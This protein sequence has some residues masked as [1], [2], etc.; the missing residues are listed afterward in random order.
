[1]SRWFDHVCDG[2]WENKG[3]TFSNSSHR[4]LWEPWSDDND[5]NYAKCPANRGYG[6]VTFPIDADDL[7]EGAV[8]DS[9][10]V[11]VRLKTSA[12]S[13]PRAVSVSV[14]SSDDMSRFTN[15]TLYATSAFVTY[16]LGT[17]SKDPLGYAWDIHRLNKLRLRIYALQDT[18]DS[19]RVA[20]LWARVNYH[21]R[22]TTTVIAPSGT[23]ITPTP[24][25]QWTYDQADAEPQKSAEYRIFTQQKVTETAFS[26][27]TATPVLQGSVSGQSTVVRVGTNFNNGEY[28]VYVRTTSQKGATSNWA[29]KSFTVLAPSPGVPG[30]D[31]AG[32]SGIPGVGT[33]TAIPDA[34]SSS[35][36]LRMRDASNLLS[37]QQADFEILSDPLEYT[38]TG[39][40][41][42]RSTSQ[43]FFNGEAS[44]SV[45]STA[46][47]NV[48]VRSTP[49]EV[50]PSLPITL[51]TQVL[52]KTSVRAV[53]L[54]AEFYDDEFNLLST[55]TAVTDTDSTTTWRELV[56][57]TTTPATTAYL[58]LLVTFTSVASGEVHYMDKVGV[59]YG[60]GA[61][62]T[63][64]GHQ[65]RNVLSSYLAT[66]DDPQS[67]T[68]SWEQTN[69]ATTVQRVTTS[70]T[71]AHG[72][73]THQ[74][75]YAGAS[76]GITFR[77]TS[78]VYT[79]PTTGTNFTL[80][81]PAGVTDN[82]LLLAFVTSTEAGDIVPPT[83]WTAVN[84][85]SIDDPDGDVAL[86]ILKRTAT[87]ADPATWTDGRLSVASARRSAVV[88]AYAG[89]AHADDQFIA[90]N[91]RSDGA[92]S[93]THRTQ[94]VT[95]W[96][97]K[98][99]RVAAFAASSGVTGGSLSANITPPVTERPPPIH[100]IGKSPACIEHK[101]NNTFKLYR[102]EGV[103]SGDL[104]VAGAVFSGRITSVTP[105][106]GWS[107]VR[108]SHQIFPNSSNGD[109]HSGDV[110]VAVFK[111]TAGS[112][113]PASWTGSHSDW[114]QP[115][116][117]QVLAYRNC[118]DASTQ[119]TSE[120]STGVTNQHSAPTA[121]ITNNDSRSWRISMFGATTPFHS[122]WEGG[123]SEQRCSSSTSLDNFPDAVISFSDSNGEISTGSHYRTGVINSI[124]NQ[125][126]NVPTGNFFT[127]IGWI[128][129]IK[130][131]PTP[132]VQGGNETERTDSTIGNPAPWITTAVYDSNGAIPRGET[133][134]YGQFN[135]GTATSANSIVSWIGIIK[136]A[137]S[138]VDG[139]AQVRT[140][141]FVDISKIGDPLDLAG[142]KLTVMSSFLGSS[143]GQPMLGLQF[144]RANQLISE[145]SAPGAPFGTSVWRKAWASFTV[146]SGTTRVRP[147]ISALN[148]SVGD[149]VKFD[150]I[151]VLLGAP[152][153]DETP[154]WRNGTAR[155]EH[156]VWSKP[157]I[158]YTDDTGSGYG[159]WSDL[160]AQKLI[161]PTF[162]VGTGLLAYID[163]TVIPLNQRKYR[164]QTVAYG[165]NGDK[166]LSGW[167]PESGEV[168]FSAV[169]W[170]LKDFANLEGSL[171]AY[172]K[173]QAIKVETGNTA[174]AFQPLGES[175]PIVL[176]EGFKGDT[177]SFTFLVGGGDKY[178]GREGE[179]TL[180]SLLRS[181]K[182]LFLQ[183]DQDYAWWVRPTDNISATTLVTGQRNQYPI[184]EITVKFV[185]V[186]PE[187]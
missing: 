110:T 170:W 70:G 166:F 65:S 178:G 34:Y 142:N 119:F 112:S 177:V 95:N 4:Q 124:S 16:E 38:A 125:F 123:D 59:M 55:S 127:A 64:G 187:E 153:T 27:D 116:V 51:R 126:S 169:N 176:T 72:S 182:T 155:P 133:S 9:I 10:S 136:P 111:R 118:A 129:V 91:V 161:P 132:P 41:L 57:S 32:L 1:M 94:V 14:L 20:K 78:S 36:Q 26:P 80:N 139:M 120:D 154:V 98:A 131:L 52:A 13:G 148:R 108:R 68:S 103:R 73:K 7:P 85:A 75:T 171:R 115:K 40:N 105:P 18:L 163:H 79:T 150:R 47:G 74:M 84:T 60:Q 167:G 66:G 173:A 117:T 109:A 76:A 48:Q 128:G 19:I 149:T 61:A 145:Q 45:T 42:A 180:Y 44:M 62:W 144:Y 152:G 5:S 104:M 114:A 186:K 101:N 22:P 184:K 90:E 185:Q 93:L 160:A 2:E 96:D 21:L 25:I 168:S 146:P 33:P 29:F 141:T 49:V 181:G 121:T 35:A 174:T 113:E 164:V 137:S 158:Q 17:Y 97:P 88:L 165:L 162:T 89:A 107:M 175:Y 83:G 151:G 122:D 37:V 12:G 134:L 159:D 87:A 15:K 69:A 58:Q 147:I 138:T 156:T 106:S 54:Q 43:S 46:A 172:V 23:I 71:G 102:P 63:D 183:S 135:P 6:T 157:M 24:E 86:F 130:P 67:S 82:D 140:N 56:S 100:Y 8:I 31:N 99:W 39:A 28:R 11:Y 3:W 50:A 179:A 92:G 81:K 143:D 30:D 53:S 77:A